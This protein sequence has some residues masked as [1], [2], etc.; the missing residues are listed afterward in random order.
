[1]NRLYMYQSA[2]LFPLGNAEWPAPLD[3]DIPLDHHK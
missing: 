1:M 2:N 3:G